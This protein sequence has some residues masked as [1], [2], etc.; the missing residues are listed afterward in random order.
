MFNFDKRIREIQQEALGDT[1]T[2]NIAVNKPPTPG[3]TGGKPLDIHNFIV[4]ATMAANN[5][6]NAIDTLKTLPVDTI[7]Q[8]KNDPAYKS[9][10]TTDTGKKIT[11]FIDT[12]YNTNKPQQ[13]QTTTQKD[14]N[15]SPTAIRSSI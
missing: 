6:K 12:F 5:D 11:G 10:T 2:T 1:L 4:L 3:Q 15:I 13:S 9:L 8:Y 14:N 7:N